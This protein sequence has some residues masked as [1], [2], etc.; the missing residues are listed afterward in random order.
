MDYSVRYPKFLE[1]GIEVDQIL[2]LEELRQ[3]I[4]EFDQAQHKISPRK[5]KSP[6]VLKTERHAMIVGLKTEE[7]L[8]AAEKVRKITP[9]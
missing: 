8:S 1:K 2:A 4:L 7:L 6:G 9:R 5:G 3:K